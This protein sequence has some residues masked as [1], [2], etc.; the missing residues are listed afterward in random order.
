ML[1]VGML[2]EL[3][4]TLSELAGAYFSSSCAAGEEGCWTMVFGYEVCSER[5]VPS[6]RSRTI[7]F[8]I[9]YLYSSLSIIR[10]LPSGR[11]MSP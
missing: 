5:E 4:L 3:A 2:L 10:T 9:V 7:D 11:N 8:S 1:E 6:K